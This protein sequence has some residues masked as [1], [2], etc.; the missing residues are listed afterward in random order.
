MVSVNLTGD[1]P[2]DKKL[3]IIQNNPRLKLITLGV[4]W[5]AISFIFPLA[6]I[7]L[8]ISKLDVPSLGVILVV[9]SIP[10]Y[11]SVMDFGIGTAIISPLS[12]Y[13]HN[14]DFSKIA[15]TIKNTIIA[16]IGISVL[17]SLLSVTFFNKIND[18][19]AKI[20]QNVTTA[21]ETELI[22]KMI[23]VSIILNPISGLAIKFLVGLRKPIT[24]NAIPSVNQMVIFFL[25]I[26]ATEFANLTILSVVAIIVFVPLVMNFA[27]LMIIIYKY[28]TYGKF[29][30]KLLGSGFLQVIRDAK[31]FMLLNVIGI[32]SYQGDILIIGM[33]L[34]PTDGANFGVLS[35]IFLIVPLSL[36]ILMS[37]FWS[38]AASEP[39][40]KAASILLL[41]KTIRT[42]VIFA[43]SA[44]LVIIFAIWIFKNKVAIFSSITWDFNLI[45]ALSICSLLPAIVGPLATYLNANNVIKPQVYLALVMMLINISMSIALTKSIGISGP[46]WGTVIGQL[47]I[48]IPGSLFLIRRFK[49]GEV[50]LNE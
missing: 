24:S 12:K 1:S 30:E 18:L 49:F 29:T 25:M 38:E 21:D 7:P 36:S 26:L 43:I 31:N 3:G 5:R 37:Y 16:G 17:L 47:L 45:L 13:F 28:K 50:N 48:A 23:L 2:Q 35:K 11:L 4:F 8:I 15:A 46:I 42:C 33:I 32:I 10:N 22:T 40:N 19:T 6:Y 44:N 34:T 41:K 27:V 39:I 14:S 20:C 9:T